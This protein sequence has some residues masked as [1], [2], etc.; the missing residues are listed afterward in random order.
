MALAVVL[1]ACAGPRPGRPEQAAVT[2]PAQWREPLLPTSGISL[3]RWWEAFG[4]PVLDQLVDQVLAGNSD[5]AMAAAR[6]Q[7]ARASSR[8]ATAQRMPSLSASGM[9]AHQGDVDAFGRARVQD[10]WQAELSLSY[11]LD[12][13]GRLADQDAAARATLLATDAARSTLRLALIATTTSTYIALRAHEAR[14]EVLKQTLQMRGESLQLAWRRAQQG[15]SSRLEVE[16]SQSEYASAEQLIAST[17]MAISR[18]ENALSL[19]AGQPALPLAPGSSLQTLALPAIRP[20]QPAALLRQRPDIYQAE[21]Q[22]V[23]ADHSLDAA[24]AALMPSLRIGLSGGVVGSNLL[25][26]PLSIFSAGGS[27][28]APLLDGGRLRAQA[29]ATAAR[30]DEAAYAYQKAVLVAWRDV[31]DA[32]AAVRAAQAQQQAVQEQEVALR[33]ALAMSR[34]RYRAGYSPY[35]EQLDAQ[36]GL[37]SAQLLEVQARADRLSATVSLAQALGGGWEAE[38]DQDLTP[39]A[40]DGR[41]RP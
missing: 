13:F 18:D 35:L 34:K 39:Q 10:A 6:V 4:D 11:E 38:C 12:L 2:L 28:L 5:L 9:G 7:Q 15:Y 32:L 41:V 36:R 30:R 14:L 16:Q 20:D 27:I 19:L 3:S 37:L 21:Q 24:R 40:S 31:E 22:L 29:D 1:A 23:A 26:D 17:R 8:F 25:P 33:E